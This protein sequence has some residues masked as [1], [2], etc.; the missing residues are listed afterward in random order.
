MRTDERCWWVAIDLNENSA[1]N[2]LKETHKFDNI[3]EETTNKIFST[4]LFL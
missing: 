3:N 2:V 4:L 1:P